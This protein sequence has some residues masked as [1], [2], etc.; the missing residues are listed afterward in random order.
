MELV[1]QI[2]AHR[3]WQKMLRHALK[4][5]NLRLNIIF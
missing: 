2:V 4:F 3:I 1:I 5:L